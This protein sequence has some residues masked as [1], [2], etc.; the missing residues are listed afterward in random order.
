MASST[1]I[2]PT[3]ASGAIV[4]KPKFHNGWTSEQ[5]EL[6]S[7]WADMG[8]C[9]RW[10]HDRCEKLFSKNNMSITIPVIILSTLTGTAS[11]GLNTFV[12]EDPEA[13][14]FGQIGIGIVSLIAGILTT[15]GN[16][17]RYAQLMESHRVAGIAWGKFQRQIAVELSLHPN[18]RLDSMDFIKICRAE[19]DR[20]IEQS[21]AIPDS[22]IDQF[23]KEF[24]NLPQLKR[25]DI[26]H[27]IE[28]TEAFKASNE[29]MKVLAGEASLFLMHKKKLLKDE[30]IPDIDNRLTKIID[31]K[32]TSLKE[33]LG[34]TNVVVN[35][36]R[37]VG[38]P[39][40]TAMGALPRTGSSFDP[41]WRKLISATTK[42]D[43]TSGGLDI[44]I[45]INSVSNPVK[46]PKNEKSEE[47]P[48]K[49]N[50]LFKRGAKTNSFY[51]ISAAIVE[52][53]EK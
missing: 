31:T 32:I 39:I 8:T 30:I 37:G 49:D 53:Q 14:K 13:Q 19:L 40:P 20:L 21:P 1:S 46:S 47:V 44:R 29:R 36:N 45:P 15:L 11:V 12:G 23:T 17:L 38:I 26:A 9:Y 5:E 6:M 41:D 28:H 48:M 51:D 24:K 25:P 34:N 52:V 35:P 33:E 3:D 22:I 50:P 10:L 7:K 42:K 18:D 16:F 43:G 2:S 27:G 4:R